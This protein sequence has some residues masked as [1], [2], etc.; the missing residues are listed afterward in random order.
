MIREILFRGQTRRKGEKVFLDGSPVPSN[1]VYGGVFPGTGNHSLIYQSDPEFHKYPVYTDTL[2]QFTGLFDKDG[3][4]IFEG[5]IVISDNGHIGF[6]SFVNGMFVKKCTC[7]DC[8]FALYGDNSEILGNFYDNPE[9]L[10]Y[11]GAAP[12][13]DPDRS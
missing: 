10:S 3:T 7:H 12:E 11:T 6:V 8:C 4:K 2:G 1:W 9:L 5:D 13:G